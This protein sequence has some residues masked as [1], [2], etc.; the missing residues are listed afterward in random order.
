M[1]AYVGTIDNYAKRKAKEIKSITVIDR[2]KE[3]ALERQGIT[4]EPMPEVEVLEWPEEEP[5]DLTPRPLKSLLD[6][7]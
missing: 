5:V 2:S 7:W 1:N 4:P 6:S 3:R